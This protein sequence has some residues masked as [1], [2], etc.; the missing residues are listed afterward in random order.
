MLY[1]KS[2]QTLPN[3]VSHEQNRREVADAMELTLGEFDYLGMCLEGFF[4]GMISFNSQAQVAKVVQHCS[5]PGLYSGIFGMYLQHRGSQKSTDRAKNILFY[6][7]WVLYASTTA[8]IIV[9]ILIFYWNDAVSIDDHRCLTFFQLFLQNIEIQN[10]LKI[11]EVTAFACCDFIAQ[12]ILVRTMAMVIIIHLILQKIYRCWIVWGYSI[13][14][15]IFP[16]FL[17]FAFLG[18]LIYLSFTD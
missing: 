2:C 9:D 11:I 8:T 10:Q 16:S 13:R 1:I 3:N 12:S 7:L 6:A 14:V 17:T 5:I 18:T 15:V 4:F